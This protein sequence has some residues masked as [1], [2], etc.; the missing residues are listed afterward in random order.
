MSG[1]GLSPFGT[2]PFGLPSNDAIAEVDGQFVSS[3]YLQ[4]DGTAK[5][6]DD[7]TGAFVGMSDAM[8][9]AHIL[10]AYGVRLPEILGTTTERELQA[11][12]ENAL[13]PLTQNPNPQ[14]ELVRVSYADNG[15]SFA[16]VEIQVRDLTDGGR[17]HTFT[18]NGRSR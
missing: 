8:Q 3:R 4:A 16:G 10:L 14:V 2:G 11:A 15:G 18:P 17:T 6:T 13:E 9:R 1:A 7:D 5:Q 12:Y